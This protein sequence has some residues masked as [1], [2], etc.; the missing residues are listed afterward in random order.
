MFTLPIG[1]DFEL[2]IVIYFLS[3]IGI[4]TPKLLKQYRKHFIV[5]LLILAGVITPS[6]DLVSQLLV[7]IPLYSLFEIGIVVSGRVQKQREL[8]AAQ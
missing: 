4:V 3:K 8:K 5:V 2:P 7:F 6:P 1:L